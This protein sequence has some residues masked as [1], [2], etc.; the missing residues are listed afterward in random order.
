MAIQKIEHVGIMVSNYD[1]SVRFYNETVGLDVLTEL[2]IE[3]G[4]QLAFL[5]SKQS[6]HIY[7]E[8][9]ETLDQPFP[10][11]GRV[12]HVAFTVSDLASEIQTLQEKGVTFLTETPQTLP[13][14]AQYI[15][16]VGPD[17]ER[18][19]LFQPKK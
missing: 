16:F 5:G 13:N 7:L 1:K 12:H 14:G 3:G 4:P 18:I 8:I 15:F 19:E 11:E 10:T 2:K 6:G 9:V 17:E